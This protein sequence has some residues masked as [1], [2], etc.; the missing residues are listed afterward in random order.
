[1]PLAEAAMADGWRN[2]YM[3]PFYALAISFVLVLLLGL[4]LPGKASTDEPPD[5]TTPVP[6]QPKEPDRAKGI[7]FS[8]EKFPLTSA[9]VLWGGET[10]VVMSLDELEKLRPTEP[11]TVCAQMPRGW[12]AVDVATPDNK[13]VCW[14]P[15]K[16]EADEYVELAVQKP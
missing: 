16:P 11:V 8:E 10:K 9:V 12:S 13:L 2:R 14:G 5:P 4:T 7:V 15:I 6:T 1:M 3:A